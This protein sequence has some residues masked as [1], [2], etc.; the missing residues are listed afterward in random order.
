LGKH[1]NP[2]LG[3]YVGYYMGKCLFLFSISTIL[4]VSCAPK[5]V[6]R[7]SYEPPCRG[8]QY[9]VVGVT[10]LIPKYEVGI[11]K[12]QTGFVVINHPTYSNTN[13]TVTIYKT[14]SSKR[15]AYTSK[16]KS[17]PDSIYTGY[18]KNGSIKF[19]ITPENDST[20]M[21]VIDEVCMQGVVK[22]YDSLGYPISSEIYSNGELNGE[23]V[24]YYTN[25]EIKAR[26]FY[27]NGKQDKEWTYYDVLGK[28]VKKEIFPKKT[29]TKKRKGNLNEPLLVKYVAYNEPLIT[30]TDVNIH[31]NKVDSI[32]IYEQIQNKLYYIIKQYGDADRFKNN[33]A[34]LYLRVSENGKMSIIGEDKHGSQTILVAEPEINERISPAYY[35]NIPTSTYYR[36]KYSSHWQY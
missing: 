8:Q 15:A 25:W 10:N 31:F 2:L 26:G 6:Q 7:V 36:I 17:N 18:Y 34:E 21:V 12:Q 3:V 22:T 11:L 24:E 5:K 9:Q 32:N 28:R 1:Y 20:P 4:I 16:N 33:Y 29:K 13:Y 27:L 30:F 35:C 23:Y 19:N 14:D